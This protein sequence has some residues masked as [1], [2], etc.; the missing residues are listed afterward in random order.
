MVISGLQLRVVTERDRRK[1]GVVTDRAP[2]KGRRCYTFTHTE[3]ACTPSR[4]IRL[5][6]RVDLSDQMAEFIPFEV[7]RTAVLT[8]LPFFRHKYTHFD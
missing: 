2:E 3:R 8:F 5:K 7:I 6:A 4:R 1:L